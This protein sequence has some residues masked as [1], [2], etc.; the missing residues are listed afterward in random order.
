MKMSDMTIKN[1]EAVIKRGGLVLDARCYTASL[2]GKN[3][4]LYPKESFT[5]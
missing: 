1:H 5:D 4:N 3:L 2:N